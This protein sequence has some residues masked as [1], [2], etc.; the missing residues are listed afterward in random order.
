MKGIFKL[1]KVR[2][3]NRFESARAFSSSKIDDE[4]LMDLMPDFG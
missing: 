3:I 4:L 2:F 1:G